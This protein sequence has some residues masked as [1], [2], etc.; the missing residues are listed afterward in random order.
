MR[1]QKMDN[2]E[3]INACQIV[4]SIIS[5]HNPKTLRI[6]LRKLIESFFL[7]QENLTGPWVHEV[8]CSYKVIDDA[9]KLLEVS[10]GCEEVSNKFVKKITSWDNP[11]SL[12]DNLG[13]LIDSYF[14]FTSDLGNEV[15]HEIYQTYKILCEALRSMEKSNPYKV[16]NGQIERAIA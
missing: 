12:E 6:N 16:L 8:Y 1:E 4:N 14:L 13:E 15:N 9:L 10:I 3:A 5:E 7:Y 11:E 2:Q